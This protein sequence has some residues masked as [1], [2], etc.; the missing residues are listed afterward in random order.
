MEGKVAEFDDA[1]E[2]ISKYKAAGKETGNQVNQEKIR[3]ELHHSLLPQLGDAD[4]I[5]YDQRQGTIRFTGNSA[6]EEWVDHAQHKE[7]E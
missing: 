3:I 7:V 6:L 5:D 2:G 4:V 1:V